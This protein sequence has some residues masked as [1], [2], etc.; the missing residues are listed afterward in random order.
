MH[1]YKSTK[2]QDFESA[3][4]D[5]QYRTEQRLDEVADQISQFQKKVSQKSNTYALM[6]EE[7]I[8]LL[9]SII[10]RLQLYQTQEAGYKFYLKYKPLLDKVQSASDNYTQLFKKAQ[11]MIVTKHYY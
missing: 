1:K 6:F 2:F 10:L 5:V 9:E 7:L 4:C 11:N 3:V 8:L